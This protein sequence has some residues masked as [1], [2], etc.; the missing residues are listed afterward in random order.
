MTKF[1]D[2]R[3]YYTHKYIYFEKVYNK[4]NRANKFFYWK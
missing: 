4:Y 1:S 3:V 2:S